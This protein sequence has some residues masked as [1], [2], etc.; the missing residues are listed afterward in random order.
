MG[1]GRP[2]RE[3]DDPA[4]R[5]PARTGL[6]LG[7]A[8]I[9]SGTLFASAPP[10]ARSGS[11]GYRGW[12]RRRSDSRRG[13][14]G[15]G[16]A[17][18]PHRRPAGRWRARGQ[19]PHPRRHR[20]QRLQLSPASHHRQPRSRRS[21]Q[22]RSGLRCPH[23][24]R[25]TVRGPGHSPPSQARRPVRRRACSRWAGPPRPR[26]ATRGRLRPRTGHRPAIR[27]A[28]QRSR[29]CRGRRRLH[30]RPRHSSRRAGRDPARSPTPGRPGRPAHLLALDCRRHGR[31]A[32]TGGRAP[33]ARNRRLG[34]AQHRLH[35]ATRIR[36]RPC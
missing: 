27:A 32:R 20:E 1:C 10:R 9:G 7:A 8:R 29:G 14:R 17:R 6:A 28:R 21:A 30:H 12:H 19:G 4:D 23:R 35:R 31:R 34:R 33:R 16:P 22:G 3:T 13:G 26:R 36:A 25:N 11:F 2:D 15:S 18:L 5:R 24:G